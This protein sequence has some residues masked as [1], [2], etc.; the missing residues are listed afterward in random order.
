MRNLIIAVLSMSFCL[1]SGVQSTPTKET[2][3]SLA[4]LW[5]KPLCVVENGDFLTSDMTP[6]KLARKFDDWLNAKT[7][8]PACA[9]VSSTADS[10]DS[11]E[12]PLPE[13]KKIAV[14]FDSL[15]PNTW[16][17]ILRTAEFRLNVQQTPSY[18]YGIKQGDP[19]NTPSSFLAN[20]NHGILSYGGPLHLEEMFVDSSTRMSACLAFQDAGNPPVESCNQDI[21]I[22]AERKRDYIARVATAVTVD[23]KY[24]EVPRF[25]SGV[26]SEEHNVVFPKYSRIVSGTFDPAKLFRSAAE[27]KALGDYSRKFKLYHHDS[28]RPDLS[29][30]AHAIDLF[31]RFC[32]DDANVSKDDTTASACISD[33]AL[34]RKTQRL[35]VSFIPRI[36]VTVTSPF[37]LAKYGSLFIQPPNRAGESLYNVALSWNFHSVIPSASSRVDNLKT[38]TSIRRGV[39]N[40]EVSKSKSDAALVQWKMKVR[41][42]YLTLL[43]EPDRSSDEDWWK[44]FTSLM[45]LMQT[46]SEPD[47]TR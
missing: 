33:F 10:S 13:S 4:K 6:E 22:L 8:D 40:D 46:K 36:D 39:K 31:T 16:L 43:V 18:V 37:D 21:F 44:K 32:G 35:L 42:C 30:N 23:L 9:M 29:E 15:F 41:N 34:G 47:S 11:S 7:T 14:K 26:I 45:T 2:K 25:E 38:M 12:K 20:P 3:L 5:L 28:H 17:R 19:P 1:A 24:S 27:T